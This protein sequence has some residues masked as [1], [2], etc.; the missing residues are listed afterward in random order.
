MP[1]V[2]LRPSEGIQGI[3]SQMP[4]IIHVDIKST[5]IKG[6]SAVGRMTFEL[7]FE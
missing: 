4:Q 6:E 2:E 1:K 3:E 7:K 5:R